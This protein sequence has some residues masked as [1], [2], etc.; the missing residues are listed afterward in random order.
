MPALPVVHGAG[1]Y[2][3][4]DGKAPG[5]IRLRILA[6]EGAGPPA[7]QARTLAALM[8]GALKTQPASPRGRGL[9]GTEAVIAGR[10]S[11]AGHIIQLQ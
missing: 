1:R 2:W 8:S 3:R 11:K 5:T 10:L 9:P 7:K 4:R 6:P